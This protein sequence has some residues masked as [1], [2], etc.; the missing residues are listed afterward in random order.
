MIIDCGDCDAR[1]AACADCVVSV[2]LGLP[3]EGLQVGPVERTALAVLADG[4]LLPRLHHRPARGR[5]RPA[6][7]GSDGLAAAAGG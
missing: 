5:D 6:A 3:P 1:G 4:G 7:S 2:V